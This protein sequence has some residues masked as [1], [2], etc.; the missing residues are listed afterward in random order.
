MRDTL[1]CLK[2][3]PYFRRRINLSVLRLDMKFFEF[4]YEQA[5][6]CYKFFQDEFCVPLL[7]NCLVFADGID[8]KSVNVKE[9]TNRFVDAHK[10]MPSDGAFRNGVEIR[11]RIKT[12]KLQLKKHIWEAFAD[13][14]SYAMDQDNGPN[15]CYDAEYGFRLTEPRTYGKPPDQR[16]LYDAFKFVN[17][18]KFY[19]GVGLDIWEVTAMLTVARD[20]YWK[21]GRFISMGDLSIEILYPCVEDSIEAFYGYLKQI[22]LMI[23]NIAPMSYGSVEL[24]SRYGES[25]DWV[26]SIEYSD[27]RKKGGY[28]HLTEWYPYLGGFNIIP[29]TMTKR[30]DS[31]NEDVLICKLDTGGMSIEAKEPFRIVSIASVRSTLENVLARGKSRDFSHVLC[32]LTLPIPL[33]DF[34]LDYQQGRIV[35][36]VSN[37]HG[38]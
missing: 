2:P 37:K 16:Y 25:Y 22:A 29:S 27:E 12:D 38:E 7:K 34:G 4:S 26:Y 30:I 31:V 5:L 36:I 13:K 24:G 28:D 21:T 1:Q 35:P 8:G 15:E 19:Y 32:P 10:G 3:T 14:S 18:D 9:I 20:K 17:T 11:A 6:E 33:S 23:H